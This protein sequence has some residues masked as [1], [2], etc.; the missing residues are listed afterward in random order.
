MSFASRRLA[1]VLVALSALVALAFC[2]RPASAQGTGWEAALDLSSTMQPSQRNFALYL[3]PPHESSTIYY[4]DVYG[5]YNCGYC[6]FSRF[7]DYNLHKVHWEFTGS[8]SCLHQGHT[9]HQD[10]PDAHTV[11]WGLLG[12][13]IDVSEGWM[14]T[15]KISN[16][17]C[18]HRNNYVRAV[19]EVARRQATIPDCSCGHGEYVTEPL[20]FP[21]ASPTSML[22]TTPGLTSVLTHKKYQVM[23]F[24]I[25]FFNAGGDDF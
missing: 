17:C 10:V 4:S 25:P 21:V 24:N 7:Y 5:C 14:E 11:I 13:P 6:S 2:P 12:T 8:W 23:S 15:G 1:A 16:N 18:C 22:V 19:I 9:H 3:I 20:I